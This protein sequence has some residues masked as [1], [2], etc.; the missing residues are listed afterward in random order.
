[1]CFPTIYSP[2]ALCDRGIFPPINT[3]SGKKLEKCSLFVS[4]TASVQIFLK[5]GACRSRWSSASCSRL[6]GIWMSHD[7]RL[8]HVHR[9]GVNIP[10]VGR[11]DHENCGKTF[12]FRNS[13]YLVLNLSPPGW[14]FVLGRPV[15]F[16]GAD[17]E[18]STK[19]HLFQVQSIHWLFFFY[20]HHE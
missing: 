2:R 10:S 3:C 11:E 17:V 1:M 19:F 18:P 4:A 6:T 14:Q 8:T 7:T 13:D 20:S 12:F 16:L 9:P 5:L 15:C